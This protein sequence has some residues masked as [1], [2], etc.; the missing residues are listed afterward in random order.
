MF[1]I[2]KAVNRILVSDSLKEKLI[3]TLRHHK[4]F[5]THFEQSISFHIDGLM[6]VLLLEDDEELEREVIA[7]GGVCY[8]VKSL[9]CLEA[10]LCVK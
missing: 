3:K 2:T 8:R 7:L 1:K 6:H 9:K 5:F 10:I 4:I